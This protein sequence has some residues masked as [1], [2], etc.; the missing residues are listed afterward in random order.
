MVMRRV[1]TIFGRSIGKTERAHIFPKI[2]QKSQGNIVFMA[3]RRY[4]NRGAAFLGT[5]KIGV[6]LSQHLQK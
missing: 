5:T 2:Y 6:V 1:M 4:T 3:I